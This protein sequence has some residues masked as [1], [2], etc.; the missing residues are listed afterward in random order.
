[1][2][3]I[4]SKEIIINKRRTFS[5]ESIDSIESRTMSIG[6]IESITLVVEKEEIKS[7]PRK[8]ILI[9]DNNNN[10]KRRVRDA[11]LEYIEA[12]PN[13]SY[14]NQLIANNAWTSKK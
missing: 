12:S 11:E 14:F 4:N 8:G 1:M 2:S 5:S 3:R 10:K 9:K 7:I 13:I 6:S